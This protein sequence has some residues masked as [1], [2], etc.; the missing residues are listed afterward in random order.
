MIFNVMK[1]SIK[2]PLGLALGMVVCAC[3]EMCAQ[4]KFAYGVVLI[5]RTIPPRGGFITVSAYI[6]LA[7]QGAGSTLP[8]LFFARLLPT[9]RK[10]STCMLQKQAPLC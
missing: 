10:F 5:S 8:A 1:L 9:A 3:N 7:V 4:Q 6:L 2:P